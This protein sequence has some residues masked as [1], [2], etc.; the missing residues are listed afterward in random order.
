[1]DDIKGA[2]SEPRVLSQVQGM[3]LTGN[4]EERTGA[5]VGNI[6]AFRRLWA[7][8]RSIYNILAVG[9]LLSILFTLLLPN[10]YTSTTTLMPPENPSSSYNLSSLASSVNVAASAGSALLQARSQSTLFVGI[11]G[12]RTV[13]ESLVKRFDLVHYYHSKFVEDACKELESNTKIQ[14]DQKSGILTISVSA[15]NPALASNLSQFYVTELDRVVTH[16]ST[17]A[18]HRERIFL[19]ERLKEIKLDLDNSSKALS[20]YSIKSR[21]I[22][23]PAQTKAMVEAAIKLQDQLLLARA[24]VAGLR[25][26][27]SEDNTRVRAGNARVKEIE[28]QLNEIDGLAKR[29]GS[30]VNPTEDTFYPSIGE[31]PALGLTYADLNRRVLV[32]EALWETLTKQYEAAK[33]QEAKEIPTVRVLDEANLPQRKS[34][35]P[36]TLIVILGAILSLFTGSILVLARSAWEEMDTQDDRKKLVYEVVQTAVASHHWYWRLPG[37]RWVYARL[38]T[39]ASP[40]GSLKEQN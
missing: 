12:S 9:T 4:A 35:P 39:T 25:Q 11:L 6:Y 15:K 29:T 7:G 32:E 34:F 13:Q 31:L 27:Y 5:E 36:R 22:D 18:A 16:N 30:G 28:R 10:T 40:P 19:E 3:E 26:A 17:S 2:A 23:M 24:D 33:V 38:L 20:L 21:T 1:M 8:R 14:L 37:L